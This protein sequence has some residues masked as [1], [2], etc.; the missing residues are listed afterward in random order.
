MNR[1]RGVV[2][3]LLLL[4]LP[5]CGLLFREA[6]ED[7]PNA[8][9]GP[10]DVGARGEL[11]TGGEAPDLIPSGA[12]RLSHSQISIVLQR[13]DLRM[14]V[15]PLDEGII[16]T[17]APDTWQR[18]N[19][20]A[21]SYRTTAHLRP[22]ADA[23]DA[24][25]LVALH[26]ETRSATF[27]PADVALTSQGVRHL[28]LDIQGLTPGWSRNRVDPRELEMAIY[29]FSSSLDPAD[30]LELEYQEVRSRDWERRLPAI[31][32]EQARLMGRGGG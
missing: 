25:F 7:D 16:R 3:G 17:A 24:L 28:P 14:L 13:G 21:E 18:L 1:G 23:S 6:P 27:E 10:N 15:T 12:G 31:L 5:A 26:A 19:A 32:S 4:V 29:A 2:T 11:V 9:P 30:G 20:L 22:G 8:V